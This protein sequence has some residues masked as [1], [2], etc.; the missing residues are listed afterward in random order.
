MTS[1]L[2]SKSILPVA[3][4]ASRE[5]APLFLCPIPA[6]W[7]SPAEDY[8]EDTL[9]LHKF[10]VR[11]EA[12]TFFLRAS[13][14]SMTGAGIHDGDILVVDRSISPVSGKV[15]IIAIDG[16]LTVKRLVK[17]G[18]RLLLIPENPSY[19]PIDITHHEDTRIWGVVTHALHSL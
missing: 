6:G 7:P 14:D 17:K 1:Q 11:N 19:D 18:K 9:D 2:F 5:G 13:G 15:V 12:A 16:E 3:I 10:A 8:V 4:D